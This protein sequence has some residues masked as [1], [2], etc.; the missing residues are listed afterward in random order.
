MIQQHF[1]IIDIHISLFVP[2]PNTKTHMPITWDYHST[3][4]R[5]AS[6]LKNKGV[7]ITWAYSFSPYTLYHWKVEGR[8][9]V[10]VPNCSRTYYTEVSAGS[11]VEVKFLLQLWALWTWSKLKFMNPLLYLPWL[12]LFHSILFSET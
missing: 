2:T 7:L 5:V 10:C 11:P 1:F 8:W 3:Q 12:Y 4:P 9:A 6:P